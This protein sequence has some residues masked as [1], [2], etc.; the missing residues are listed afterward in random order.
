V[1][2]V[3]IQ[4]KAGNFSDDI[5]GKKGKKGNY[6]LSAAFFS[7][8]SKSFPILIVFSEFEIKYFRHTFMLLAVPLLL[9]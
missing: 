3:P 2:L 1:T 8:L 6:F 7:R 4:R 9:D 5:L